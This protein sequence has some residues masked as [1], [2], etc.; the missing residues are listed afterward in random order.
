[1]LLVLSL[2]IQYADTVKY[3]C[4]V[5]MMYKMG[6]S[7][8]Y[9]HSLYRK[10]AHAIKLAVYKGTAGIIEAYSVKKNIRGSAARIRADKMGDNY[11]PEDVPPAV[12]A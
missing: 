9:G 12:F 4:P 6:S 10:I 3:E 1:M 11:L 2:V 8:A 7:T 5:W